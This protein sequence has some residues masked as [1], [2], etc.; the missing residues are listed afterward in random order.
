[1]SAISKTSIPV[2]PPGPNSKR[3]LTNFNEYLSTPR[4]TKALAVIVLLLS[5]VTELMPPILHGRL[6]APPEIG[7]PFDYDAI[8]FSLWNGNGFSIDWDNPKVKTPYRENNASGEYDGVLGATGA[9]ITSFRPPLF[10][11][12]LAGTYKIFGRQF[13]P[14]RVINCTCIALSVVLGFLLVARYFGS[15]PALGCAAL[16]LTSPEFRLYGRQMLTESSACFLI[17]LFAWSLILATDDRDPLWFLAA[18]GFFA[19]AILDRTMFALW[20]PV[21]LVFLFV[22]LRITLGAWFSRENLKA[23]LLIFLPV[24]CLAGPWMIRNCLLFKKFQPLGTQGAIELPS[25][26]S[27]K[28]YQDQGR[29]YECAPGGWY[30]EGNEQKWAALGSAA[31]LKWIKSNLSKLPILAFFKVR[32][33]FWNWDIIDQMIRAFGLLG[34]M[35]W[36]NSNSKCALVIIGMVIASVMAVAL[37]WSIG[38]RF[39]IPIYPLLMASSAVGLWT[40]L[41]VY[42]EVGTERVAL[43]RQF[44]RYTS[45]K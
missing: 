33:E 16:L 40:F 9:A 45:D 14:I 37:T 31:G 34:L 36:L 27:D 25:G 10:P 41:V 6:S 32:S 30:G 15:I 21:L 29:W 26:Y 4:R 11:I 17:M 28:A 7:D 18:G 44:Q 3:I 42:I 12:I 23:I 22:L 35:I 13:W 5:F 1:M 20:T 19:L 2:Q 38:G 8:A 39:L 43:L 24:A